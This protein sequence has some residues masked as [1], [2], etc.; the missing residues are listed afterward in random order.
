MKKTYTFFLA[1]ALACTCNITGAQTFEW[2]AGMGGGFQDAGLAITVDDS[3]N[4]YTTGYFADTVD[5]DPDTGT[6]NLISA[7]AY[8]VFVSKLN[9]QGKLVWVKQWGANDNETGK[10]IAVDQSGNVYVTGNFKDTVDFDPG[11]GNFNL[12][13]NGGVDQ[14]ISKLD[15]SGDLL[16][17]IN[18]GGTTAV[19]QASSL[20]LDDSGNI[21]TTGYIYGTCD[22]DPGG[23]T[24]NLNTTGGYAIFVSKYTPFGNLVWAGVMPGTTSA[25]GN[26]LAIS[27]SGSVC[28]TGALIGTVD[29]D[30]DTTTTYNLTSAG[31]E[32]NFVCKLDASGNLIWAKSME[33]TGRGSGHSVAVDDSGNIYSIGS[34]TDTI[35]FDPDPTM[36][37]NMAANSWDVYVSKLDASGNFLWARK[38]GGSDVDDGASI[39]VDAIG[40]VYTTGFFKGQVDFDPDTGIYNITATAYSDI[41]ISKLDANGNLVW[42]V[43]MDGLQSEWGYAITVDASQNVYTTGQYSNTMDFDPDT[44]TY[45]LTST[46]F[47]DCFVQKLS[48]CPITFGTETVTAC[49][50]YTSP[51]GNETYMVS[52]TYM[53]TLTNAEGCDSLVNINLTIA[54]SADSIAETACYTYVVPSGDETHSSSG[55]YMDTIPNAAG[56]D[57][58]LTIN[59]TIEGSTSASI[60]ET[61]CYN[62]TVPSGD[63]TY[64][65]SGVYSDTIPNSAG[66]DSIVTINLTIT[67]VDVSVTDNSPT[68]I[69]N[70]TG[71]FYQWTYC[72]SVSVSGA[73][74]QAYTAA[75]SGSYAVIITQNTCVDTSVCYAVNIIGITEDD[76]AQGLSVFPNPAIGVLNIDFGRTYQTISISV[77]DVT[78]KLLTMNTYSSTANV[79]LDMMEAPGMYFIDVSADGAKKAVLKVIKK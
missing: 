10:G 25:W 42:A 44:G 17:A 4:V 41:F 75:A 51:S 45:Y 58:I 29:F 48:Q 78:G 61:V 12:I 79:S 36:T 62:Y 47:L 65:S 63:E 13:S 23:G 56:C 28:I 49:T 39:A 37:Y 43:D 60:T 55:V 40:N 22:F 73:T 33:G 72:D 35:D 6:Y 66:C 18:V 11:V 26:S 32:D 16:W 50:S 53:D 59:L 34:F 71:V 77:K 9:I 27:D 15:A 21:F 7:G 46:A 38:W 30:P 2:A 1:I 74:N 20:A 8:D 24:Y 54:S 67:A 52:G 76:F 3:G 68:L 57:S 69:A 14:F 64:T 19:A 70:A 31:Q 5:F